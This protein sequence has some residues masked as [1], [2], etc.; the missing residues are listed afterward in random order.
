[1]LK[2]IYKIYGI[3]TLKRYQADTSKKKKN[4]VSGMLNC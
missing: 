2:I 1:M 4:K 3:I